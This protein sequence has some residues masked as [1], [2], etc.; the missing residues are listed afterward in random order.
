MN[1]PIV[2]IHGSPGKPS[3]W[4]GVIKALGEDVT[5]ITPSL[6]DHNQTYPPRDRETAA[7]AAAIVDDLGP[8]PDG[9]VLGGHSYGGNVAHRLRARL[10]GHAGAELAARPEL[11]RD[12]D[13]IQ[14]DCPRWLTL[15]NSAGIFRRNH[16]PAT[17]DPPAAWV[18]ASARTR[19]RSHFE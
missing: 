3:A 19:T 2:L 17:S 12:A 10:V 14:Q 16:E 6:P 11:P 5:A 18:R 9:I 15:R 4:K 8:Q 13:P 1:R 7:M